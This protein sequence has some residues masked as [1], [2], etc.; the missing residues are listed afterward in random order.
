MFSII[1]FVI[2]IQRKDL[3]QNMNWSSR[4]YISLHKDTR[5]E[6][7]NKTDAIASIF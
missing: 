7:E 3:N 1:V 2:K 6:K 4:A 5:Y